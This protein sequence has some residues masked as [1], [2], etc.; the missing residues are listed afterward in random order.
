MMDPPSRRGEARAEDLER[1]FRILGAEYSALIFYLGST[2]F[3][4]AART[5]LFFVALSAGGVARHDP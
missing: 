4:S 5:K 2:R 1:R 3:V